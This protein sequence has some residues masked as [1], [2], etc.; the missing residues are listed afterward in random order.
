MDERGRPLRWACAV[1]VL[2]PLV[3]HA[4]ARAEQLGE[5]QGS[6][7]AHRKRQRKVQFRTAVGPVLAWSRER[8]GGASLDASGS[9]LGINASL[10]AA[11]TK[12][13][14]LQMDLVFIHVP[15]SDYH[16]DGE[17]LYEDAAL[18]LVCFGLGAS[19]RFRTQD[20]VVAGSLGLARLGLAAGRI[21]AGRLDLPHLDQNSDVG[22]GVH[23][24]LGKHWRISQAWGLG[25]S[26]DALWLSTRYRFQ[27]ANGRMHTFALG[28]LLRAAFR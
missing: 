13:L 26:L 28:L 24:V 5:V 25:A 1:L 9:G 27:H 16:V 11:L 15:G 14:S 7:A 17:L 23:F 19:Y 21:R 3:W 18:S 12:A 22:A 10:G 20:V 2:I 4:G 8:A 6:D